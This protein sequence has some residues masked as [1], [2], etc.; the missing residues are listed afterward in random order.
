MIYQLSGSSEILKELFLRDKAPLCQNIG[1]EMTDKA[2]KMSALLSSSRMFGEKPIRLLDFDKWKRDERRAVEELLKNLPE[3]ANVFLDGSLSSEIPATRVAFELPKP[4]E[5]EK[6]VSHARTLAQALGMDAARNALE[7]LIERVGSDEFR[8]FKE[9]EKLKTVTGELEVDLVQRYV[10]CEREVE[11]ESLVFDF[12][13]NV[14]K[15]LSELDRLQLPFPLFSSVLSRTLLEI[16][17]IIELRRDPRPAGWAEIKRLSALSRISVSKT[18][19]IV[20]FNFAG[21]KQKREDLTRLFDLE[22]VQT[23]LV[24][25]QEVDEN[26]KSGETTQELAYLD[27]ARVRL[28]L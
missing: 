11:V 4:W 14:E 6:W 21:S 20:G 18:A 27:L 1:P 19:R 5:D 13:E 26:A 17:T 24:S 12:L 28:S 2:A 25:L 15:Y 7:L 8:I 22:R 16:G 23:L 10:T 9:L 3:E